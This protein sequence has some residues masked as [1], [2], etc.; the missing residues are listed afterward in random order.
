MRLKRSRISR[1]RPRSTSISAATA[2]LPLPRTTSS[3]AAN[4]DNG[5]AI[6]VRGLLG[7]GGPDV[8]LLP[9]LVREHAPHPDH[10][11][12]HQEQHLQHREDGE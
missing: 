12:P 2:S 9:A 4:D 8:L 7:Q 3:Q 1:I 6:C 10:D 5:V 11:K